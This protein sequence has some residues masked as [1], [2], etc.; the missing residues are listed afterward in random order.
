MRITKTT[1]NKL[2]T[3]IEGCRFE[4][5]LQIEN[6]FKE[7]IGEKANNISICECSGINSEIENGIIDCDYSTDC[8]FGENI[9]GF[10]YAD[11]TLD[12]IKDNENRMYITY[13][14]WN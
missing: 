10:D 12:Y 14:R 4:S 13:A 7:K 3:Q 2:F 1:I 8:T 6:W 11:F 5:F 9:F